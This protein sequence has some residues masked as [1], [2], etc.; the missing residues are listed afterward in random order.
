MSAHVFFDRSWMDQHLPASS[1]ALASSIVAI[2]PDYPFRVPSVM[3]VCLSFVCQDA[4]AAG[5][6]AFLRA[7]QH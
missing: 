3:C 5:L 4:D 6:W 7:L 1:Q 2:A